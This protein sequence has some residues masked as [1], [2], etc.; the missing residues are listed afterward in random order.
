ME[1]LETEHGMFTNNEVTE[2]TA[3][4]V[5]QDWLE[6]KSKAPKPS[7]KERLEALE[8]AVLD[9]ITGGVE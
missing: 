9:M 7:Q 2:Q 1:R 5:Y 4:E 6:N 3:E 8:Q